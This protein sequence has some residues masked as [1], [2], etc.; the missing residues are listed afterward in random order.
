MCFPP[1]D[2]E[3]KYT[4]LYRFFLPNAKILD[5]ERRDKVPY[6][7]WKEDKLITCTEG[8][9]I[10]YDFIE[11]QIRKDA[12]DYN[13]SE[14]AFDPWNSTEIVN[15]LTDDGFEMVPFRQGFA[16][17]SA[18]SKDFEKRIL[19][20]ELNHGGNPIMKWMVSCTEVKTDPAGN[21]KPVKP[22]RQKSGKRIDGVVASIMALDRA[23]QST[24][25]QSAYDER[26]VL[27]L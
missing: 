3:A 25:Q 17:L 8:N 23:V 19:G 15:H 1:I 4:F 13:I 5:K 7:L 10:D 9:V 21:I 26:G 22:D 2:L 20:K 27:S 14:I 6:T 24:K 18:P 16:S 11:A 12:E